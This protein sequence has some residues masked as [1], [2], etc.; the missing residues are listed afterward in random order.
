MKS[1]SSRPRRWLRWL[2]GCTLVLVVALAARLAYALRDRHPGYTV[3]L[4]RD[5][6]AARA[7]PRPLRVGL[8]RATLNP[9]LHDPAHPIW[10]AGFSQNRR[11]TAIHDDLWAVACVIDD[12]HT[13]I[14]FVALDA[15]GIFHDDVIAIREQLPRE[16]GLTYTVV[17]ATHN[18]STPDLMGLW[19]PHPLRTGVDPAYRDQVIRTAAQTIAAATAALTPAR[20]SLHEVAVPPS[21]LLADTRLPWVFDSDLR[22]M[23]FTAANDGHTLGS[24]VTWGNHPETPWAANTEITSDFCGALRNALEHGL[25][26]AGQP[27][28]AGL[29]GIHCFINGA[30]GGLMTTHPSVTVRD[31]V[32]GTDRKRPSHEKSRAVGHQLALRLLPVMHAAPPGSDHAPI[33]LRAR[34][35]ELPLANRL[36]WLAPAIGLL[37]RGQ[38]RWGWIRTEVASLQ[39]GDANIAC[40]PGEIY[41]EIVNGGIEHPL[42]ADL[43]GDPVEVPPLRTLM[44]G[45]VKFVFGLANDEIGYIIPRSEWDEAPPYLY[46]SNRAVYGEVNSLGP[47]TAPRLHRAFRE[48][49]E[50]SP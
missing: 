10:L 15:I 29:G 7:Q 24:V 8:A 36:M 20:L 27:A 1:P 31:P 3:R 49:L 16:L 14:A 38:S 30:V 5:D 17:C 9:P 2:L 44:S 33:A 28:V 11:A 4:D 35:L 34:T 48:L 47:E 42:G 50:F 41:P 32:T 12:G 45:R 46:G 37:D 18:H 19:G 39:I 40:V 23:H 22:V 43:A 13:R 6:R 26:P 21:G 25:T